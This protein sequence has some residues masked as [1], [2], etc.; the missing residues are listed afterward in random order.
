MEK[1]YKLYVFRLQEN[2]EGLA[3]VPVPR[4]WP[5]SVTVP[6]L[7]IGIRETGPIRARRAVRRIAKEMGM[8]S[9]DR[10]KLTEVKSL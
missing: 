10:L 1:E 9:S 5:S 2:A 3:S 7:A 6:Y 4:G 8:L